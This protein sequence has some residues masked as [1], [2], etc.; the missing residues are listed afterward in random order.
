MCVTSK[1]PIAVDPRFCCFAA[2]AA[3]ALCKAGSG[4]GDAPLDAALGDSA[5]GGGGG[6]LASAR[7]SRSE[8]IPRA[9]PRGVSCARFARASYTAQSSSAVSADSR[10]VGDPS[11]P[12]CR[13]SSKASV[14]RA[15]S[16]TS[17]GHPCAESS[18]GSDR[19]DASAETR[20]SCA[21]RDAPSADDARASPTERCMRSSASSSFNNIS[22]SWSISKSIVTSSSASSP[23]PTPRSSQT[24]SSRPSSPSRRAHRPEGHTLGR[25]ARF[26]AQG[27][28]RA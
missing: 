2:A 24:A 10:R 21:G 12:S 25:R 13:P 20:A 17:I 22:A 16:K 28:R 15:N 8:T 14:R 18:S 23:P 19:G 11:R 4:S 1:S 26:R 27:T 5:G 7:Q 3:G 9:S 6:E